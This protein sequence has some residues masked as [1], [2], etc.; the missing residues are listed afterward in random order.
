MS[1]ELCGTREY[2]NPHGLAGLMLGVHAPVTVTPALIVRSQHVDGGFQTSGLRF[3]EPFMRIV[4][5][6]GVYEE[7]PISETRVLALPYARG[8]YH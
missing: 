1:K 2:L 5:M 8:S 6:L 4:N 7:G 3:G